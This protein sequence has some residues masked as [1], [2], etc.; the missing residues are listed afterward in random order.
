MR[1]QLARLAPQHLEINDHSAAHVGH[2]QAGHGGHYQLLIVATVFQQQTRLIR[3]RLIYH[4]LAEILQHEIHALSIQAYTPEEFQQQI[5][6]R[7]N[8]G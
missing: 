1:Q 2:A 6:Q 4:T 5:A 7:S 3:H 8:N